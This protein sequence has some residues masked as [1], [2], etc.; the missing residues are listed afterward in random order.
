MVENAA[1]I[2]L[3]DAFVKVDGVRIPL[4]ER[5]LTPNILEAMHSGGFEA[6]EAEQIPR[7]VLPGDRVL[8]VGAGIGFI[9]TLL[10]RCPDVAR[11][12]AVEANPLLM[13]FMARVH[14]ENG[15]SK[16]E[17]RNA[18]LTNAAMRSMSFYLREDFWM[19]S[20]MPGP[21]PYHATIDVPTLN[22]NRLL[23]DERVSLIVCDIE[24]AEAGFFDGAD[25]SG[26]TRVFL[27][28]HD[29]VTG[30]LGVGHVFR[31]MA[32]HGFIYDPRHS[33]GSVV[34]FRKVGPE[35]LVRPYEG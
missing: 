27:E 29:H 16:V 23:R 21:N 17:R 3:L 1:A 34:L 33:N 13:D 26:V 9:S 25:L 19:G 30:L 11:V 8:E 2:T 4:D 24:G 32:D 18:V 15:A 6:E 10:S 20:L 35:D 14:A 22:L 31:V 5:V 28:L 12:I 7:I